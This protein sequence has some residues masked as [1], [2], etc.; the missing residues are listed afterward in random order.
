MPDQPILVSFFQLS[1][2][3]NYIVQWVDHLLVAILSKKQT[4]KE[5]V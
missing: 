3:W 5:D 2:Q 1:F 4:V